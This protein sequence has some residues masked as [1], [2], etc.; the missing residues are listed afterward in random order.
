VVDHRLQKEDTNRIRITARGNLI[1][2]YA[3]LLF[4]MANLVT[5]KLH[6][7]SIVS[8]ALAKYMCIDIFFFYLTAKLEY[9][10]YMMIPLALFPDWII[11][12]YDLKRHALNGKVHLKLRH[13]VWGLPQVGILANKHL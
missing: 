7:N 13:A 3:E 1:N 12:Q 2:Y 5:A 10:D 4:P 8:T 6:G 11:E 9:F